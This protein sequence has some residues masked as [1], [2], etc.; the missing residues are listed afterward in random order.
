MHYTKLY[1]NG[2]KEATLIIVYICFVDF[3]KRMNILS[4]FNFTYYFWKRMHILSHFNLT[5]PI[6]FS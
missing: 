1:T 5:Y 3:W 2:E 4:H 6:L